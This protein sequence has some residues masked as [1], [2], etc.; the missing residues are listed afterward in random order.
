MEKSQEKMPNRAA[1]FTCKVCGKEGTNGT[2]KRHIESN[3]MELAPLPC[4]LCQKP[5]KS[6]RA[7]REHKN[8]YH[9]S[10]P[11]FDNA[12]NI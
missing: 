4:N 8:K 11:T 7:L 3:H 12:L 9:E 5:C 1:K 10:K 6:S 2:I